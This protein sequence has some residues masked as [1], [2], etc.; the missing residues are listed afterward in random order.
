MGISVSVSGRSLAQVLD[1]TRSIV[2]S[3]IRSVPSKLCVPSSQ[4]SG[5]DPTSLEMA[6]FARDQL[7]FCN[8]SWDL[9]DG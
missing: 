4:I 1:T 9:G 7:P 2:D 6:S 5:R 8:R 3:V